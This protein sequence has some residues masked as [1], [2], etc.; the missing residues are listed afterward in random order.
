MK[1]ILLTLMTVLFI[2]LTGTAAV[3][4]ADTLGAR[5]TNNIIT[6]ED[7][8]LHILN[9]GTV[10]MTFTVKAPDGWVASPTSLLLSPQ[11][12]GIITLTGKGD[13][14]KVVVTG[15]SAGTVASGQ[16]RS[17]IQLSATVMATRP[18]DVTKYAGGAFWTA[19]ILIGG[20]IVMRRLRPW[21]WRLVTK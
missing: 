18:F 1:R 14:G 3:R 2:L 16:D 4:A 11:Q 8:S 19:V 13:P 5:I 20:F 15:T 6:D 9:L 7:P 17:A 10:P 12:E 21:R